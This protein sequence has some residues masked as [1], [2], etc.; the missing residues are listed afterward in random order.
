[1]NGFYLP[2]PWLGKRESAQ[3]GGAWRSRNQSTLECADLSALLGAGTRPAAPGD[4]S[5]HSKFLV[6][7]KGRKAPPTFSL[8]RLPTRRALGFRH[9]PVARDAHSFVHRLAHVVNGQRRHA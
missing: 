4:K 1:M 8:S 2:P 9:Q 5:P 6:A 3:R 7:R